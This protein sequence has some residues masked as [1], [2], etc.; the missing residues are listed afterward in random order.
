VP[1]FFIKSTWLSNNQRSRCFFQFLYFL[2]NLLQ[3]FPNEWR[4]TLKPLCWW[5]IK[6]LYKKD[7]KGLAPMFKWRKHKSHHAFNLPCVILSTKSKT[8]S[9]VPPTC[10]WLQ[11]SK[12]RAWNLKGMKLYPQ[13][14]AGSSLT[15]CTTKYWNR[16]TFKSVEP[17]SSSI[18]FSVLPNF[19]NNYLI[20]WNP[21]LY[22]KL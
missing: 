3:F 19:C 22:L 5:V 6:M 7:T 18:S 12:N 21:I 13:K 16:P 20:V 11:S 4:K 17:N 9:L 14:S 10:T 8:D 2:I 15:E 1:I